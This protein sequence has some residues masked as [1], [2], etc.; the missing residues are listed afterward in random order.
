MNEKNRFIKAIKHPEWLFGVLLRRTI[1]PYMN[2]ESFIKWEYFSGMAKF[3]DLKN[4]KTFNEKLQWLKLNDIHED[5]A[6]MVDK[7]SA[8][9][10]VKKIIGEEYIIPTLGIW[11]RF[12][13]IDFSKLPNQFVLK[14]T[15][16]S[17]GVVVVSDK[18]NFDIAE[19]RRKLNKSLRNNYFLQ[20]REYPYKYIQPRIIAEQYM[21]DE[22][23]TELKDYKFF[24]FHGKCKMLFIATDRSL[25]D[26]KFDFY[27]TEFNHLP[28]MQGHPWATKEIQ[29]P[30]CFDEMIQIAEKLSE[31]IPHVRVDLYNINGKIYFG[32]LTFFHFSGNVPF[33]PHEWDNKIG[34]WLVLPND[35]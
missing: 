26:V 12:D 17:G 32:E 3:P 20:H 18:S 28:F 31:G 7:A 21:V 1:G 16:D 29:K 23:T 6:E 13:E 27:D 35:V 24:C 25:G 5:Y 9:E 33:I 19:A 4:P 11:R 10:Y 15:H 34:E 22:S 8:K 14:T 30:E 2:D